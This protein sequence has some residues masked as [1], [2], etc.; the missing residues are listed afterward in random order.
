MFD[1]R[2][3][4]EHNLT[5]SLPQTNGTDNRSIKSKIL[6]IPSKTGAWA[7]KGYLYKMPPYYFLLFVHLLLFCV[8][9]KRSDVI[10]RSDYVGD[11]LPVQKKPSRETRI[12]FAEI[13]KEPQIHTNALSRVG[14]VGTSIFT[15]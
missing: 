11:F 15:K 13:K 14:L 2:G 9:K 3:L 4:S 12:S 7:Q 1:Q 6:P 8:V 10:V 5:A